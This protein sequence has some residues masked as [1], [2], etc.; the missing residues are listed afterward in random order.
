MSARVSENSSEC[1]LPGQRCQ[2][3]SREGDR[4][5]PHGLSLLCS[6]A[7]LM[8]GINVCHKI[9]CLSPLTILPASRLSVQEGR[10]HVPN[11]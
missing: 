10:G 4:K 3:R 11:W 6:L 9:S 2:P 7:Y 1:I 5:E 8:K